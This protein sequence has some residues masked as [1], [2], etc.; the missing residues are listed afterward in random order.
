MSVET[1]ARRYA[2]ALADVVGK[3]Y[4]IVQKELLEWEGIFNQNSDL[5]NAFRNPA[6]AHFSK[7]HLL[8]SLIS[9]TK[10]TST[11]ANFLRVLLQNG[12]LTNISE[13]NQTLS[14]VI[15]ERSGTVSAKITSA[16][17]LSESEKQDLQKNLEKMTRKNVSLKFEVN[18]E[19]IGG[20][21]TTIGSTVY[22]SSVKTKLNNLKQQLVNG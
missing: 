5:V 11:T 18:Q 12:R 15:E 20:I 2:L 9:K 3:D 14:K 4:S 10:P 19:L 6:I 1:V 8:N 13:I 22:D 7:E 16:R 21:V 17:E